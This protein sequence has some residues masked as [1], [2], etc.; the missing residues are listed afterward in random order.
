MSKN[1]KFPIFIKYSDG[2]LKT[3]RSYEDIEA[4][5]EYFLINEEKCKVYDSADQKLILNV[6]LNEVKDLYPK[7]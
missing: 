3:F 7:E 4:K 6:F 1:I 2:T 5:I